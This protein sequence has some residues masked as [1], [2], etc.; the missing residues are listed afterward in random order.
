MAGT[1]VESLKLAKLHKSQEL[2]MSIKCIRKYLF[3][4]CGCY[5]QGRL[6]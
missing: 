4:L 1:R 5:M 6:V 3:L 2:R